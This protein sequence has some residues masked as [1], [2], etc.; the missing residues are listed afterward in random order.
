MV[1]R[2]KPQFVASTVRCFHLSLKK[3][4]CIQECLYC[5]KLKVLI[6]ISTMFYTQNIHFWWVSPPPKSH[7][8][9]NPCVK[10]YQNRNGQSQCFAV[11]IW[12]VSSGKQRVWW[13][14]LTHPQKT[15]ANNLRPNLN[16]FSCLYRW[17][18]S[19]MRRITVIWTPLL[20]TSLKLRLVLLG[21]ECSVVC[22][23]LSGWQQIGFCS[24]HGHRA[25]DCTLYHT[26]NGAWK[27]RAYNRNSAVTQQDAY[28]TQ[29]YTD[30]EAQV[31]LILKLLAQN[32]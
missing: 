9:T 31:S 15:S 2:T 23:V 17:T 18:S 26:I 3:Y 12:S 32:V 19:K 29:E 16:I 14:S 24:A 5:S 11:I 30:R 25:N 21:M 6:L 20:T 10:L 13:P 1:V 22:Y 27:P 4:S 7:R 28:D 8:N